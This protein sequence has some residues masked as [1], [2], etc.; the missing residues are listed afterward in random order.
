M[1]EDKRM[2]YITLNDKSIGR[3]PVSKSYYDKVVA[4]LNAIQGKQ[5]NTEI[6]LDQND[7]GEAL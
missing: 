2:H 3:I 5:L 7:K 4:S 6:H 1:E